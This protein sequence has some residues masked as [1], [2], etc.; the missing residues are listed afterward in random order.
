MTSVASMFSQILQLFPCP[1]F[2]TL[3]KEHNAE[4]HARGFTCWGQFV[5]M[6]FCQLGRAHSLREICSGLAASEGKLR[7]L[8]LPEAP[9]RST[10]GTCT[11]LVGTLAREPHTRAISARERKKTPVA[12]RDS[13]MKFVPTYSGAA[14]CVMLEGHRDTRARSVPGSRWLSVP[15]DT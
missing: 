4:R 13:R 9:R 8:G 5:A 7:H 11:D 6:L 15:N 3:V 12:A 1:E 2:E 10:P 14:A